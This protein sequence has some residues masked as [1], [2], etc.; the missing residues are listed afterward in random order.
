MAFADD[1]ALT[2][3]H[4]YTSMGLDGEHPVFEGI[5]L[6]LQP[7]YHPLGFLGDGTACITLPLQV[8][9]IQC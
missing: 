2:K 3:T 6:I 1:Q 8:L 4:P 7:S 5:A 9:R